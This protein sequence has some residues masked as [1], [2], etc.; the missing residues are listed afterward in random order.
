MLLL[1]NKSLLFSSHMYSIEP[2]TKINS[3]YQVNMAYLEMLK[4]SKNAHEE[5]LIGVL[6]IFLYT[7][8]LE[9]INKLFRNG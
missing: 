2:H 1:P 4:Q 7:I 9:T 6:Y 3:K 5:K 8:T